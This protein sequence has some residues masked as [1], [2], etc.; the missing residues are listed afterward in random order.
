MDILPLSGDVVQM[1]IH[2]RSP[3]RYEKS[4]LRFVA[5]MVLD[6]PG[7]VYFYLS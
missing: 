2:C 6:T 5:T 4:I 3:S 1:D 7:S